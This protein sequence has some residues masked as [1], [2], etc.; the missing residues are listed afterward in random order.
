MKKR[1]LADL[2]AGKLSIEAASKMVRED[3]VK[4]LQDIHRKWNELA[5]RTKKRASETNAK[6]S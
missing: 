6:G 5:W 3:E 1:A 4:A 2:F